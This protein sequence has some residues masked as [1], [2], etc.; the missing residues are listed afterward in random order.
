[1]SDPTDESASTNPADS[2]LRFEIIESENPDRESPVKI[3][4]EV[5]INPDPPALKQPSV[6]DHTRQ[7]DVLIE[8]LNRVDR[9]LE[10]VSRALINGVG[11]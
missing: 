8:S 5:S 4:V 3:V 9:N 10:I 2:H 6:G 1:M 7:L 11:R